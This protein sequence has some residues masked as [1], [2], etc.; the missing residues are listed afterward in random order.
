VAM[1]SAFV[2]PFLVRHLLRSRGVGEGDA[3]CCVLMAVRYTVII[4]LPVLCMI[5]LDQDCAA[6]WTY[7]W[8]ECASKPHSFDISVD[9]LNL[10]HYPMPF[11]VTTH[12]DVCDA[13]FHRLN[14]ANQEGCSRAVLKNMINLMIS[15][16]IFGAFLTPSLSLLVCTVHSWASPWIKRYFPNYKFSVEAD[17]EVAGVVMLAEHCLLWG[18][19]A[20]F[21]LPILAIA[22][23]AQRA[24]IHAMFTR[25]G[26]TM[27]NV[28]R[29][30]TMYL[31]LA[32]A[33]GCAAVMWF[34]NDGNLPGARVVLWGMPL[35]AVGCAVSGIYSQDRLAVGGDTGL[36]DPLPTDKDQGKSPPTQPKD[37]GRALPETSSEPVLPKAE[38]CS[39]LQ[40]EEG[41]AVMTI[42]I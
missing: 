2:A 8:T 36:K 12:G 37:V 24:S 18:F 29:P 26:F 23:L 22:F 27:G 38:P 3:A 14:P 11:T 30:S 10:P 9:L 34:F 21:L 35:V 25:H 5:V 13:G 17:V 4:L 1:N 39:L 31:A 41:Y 42:E 15:K 28:A 40:E 20:P 6:Y 32:H 7:I 19:I 16:L 33:S